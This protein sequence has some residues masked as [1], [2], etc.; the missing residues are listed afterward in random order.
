[1]EEEEKDEEDF[2]GT[3]LTKKIFLP[4]YVPCVVATGGGH[5]KWNM[6]LAAPEPF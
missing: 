2:L 1:M 3:I 4:E 6:C 5:K